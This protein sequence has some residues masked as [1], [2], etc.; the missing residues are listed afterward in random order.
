M[1]H[2]R[3]IYG[4]ERRKRMAEEME[5]QGS[6]EETVRPETLGTF[7]TLMHSASPQELKYLFEWSDKVQRVSATIRKRTNQVST[8]MSG[9]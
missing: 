3:A 9:V 5:D 2:V 1:G 6:S 7:M 4:G 8:V